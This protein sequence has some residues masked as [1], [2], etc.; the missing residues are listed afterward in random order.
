MNTLEKTILKKVNKAILNKKYHFYDCFYTS[1]N[2]YCFNRNDGYTWHASLNQEKTSFLYFIHEIVKNT[3]TNMITEI[4][5]NFSK[6]YMYKIVSLKN[7][8]P[9]FK[10]ITMQIIGI[11]TI[12]FPDNGDIQKVIKCRVLKNLP[13]N[14]SNMYY[15]KNELKDVIYNFNSYELEIIK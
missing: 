14:Y 6:D 2:E 1:K 8:P 15:G 10:K 12:K 11:D 4:Q 5:F 3:Y 7:A 9:Q 13:F